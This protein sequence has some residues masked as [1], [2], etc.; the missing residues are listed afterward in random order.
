MNTSI[1]SDNE[2]VDSLLSLTNTYDSI[3]IS[4]VS[5]VI[6][7]SAEIASLKDYGNFVGFS[8]TKTLIV[9]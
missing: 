5:K 1:T 3:D 7:S 4:D 9:D 8:T 6:G 2:T